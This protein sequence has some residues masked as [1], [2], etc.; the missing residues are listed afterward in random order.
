VLRLR[1]GLR[2]RRRLKLRRRR[3]RRLRVIDGVEGR[4]VGGA[5]PSVVRRLAARGEK[6]EVA[7]VTPHAV[8]DLYSW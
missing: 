3:R 2:R 6:G 5:L 1:L 8:R 7:A 4:Q